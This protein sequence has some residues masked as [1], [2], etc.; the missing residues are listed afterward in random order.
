[1]KFSNAR[2][3]V[4]STTLLHFMVHSCLELIR[5]FGKYI[6]SIATVLLLCAAVLPDKEA[7]YI[8]KGDVAFNNDDYNLALELYNQALQIDPLNPKTNYKIGRCFIEL[9]QP[10]KAKVY[11]KKV[12]DLYPNFSDYQVL[13]SLAE[14]YHQDYEFEKARYYYQQEMARTPRLDWI[15]T[16]RLHKLVNECAAG[17][18][19]IN[20]PSVAEVINM[21]TQ[22]NTSFSDY[23][24]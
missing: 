17:A 15:Y 6:V 20:K 4:G 19:L 2:A 14:A 21:G 7:K 1:M 22:I 16:E 12:F 5:R 8:R 9:R 13:L 24:P 23:M 3:I 11:F 10:K 18:I